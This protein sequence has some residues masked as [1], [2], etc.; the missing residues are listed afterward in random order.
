MEKVYAYI[1]HWT[2]LL[3]QKKRTLFVLGGLA[4]FLTLSAVSIFILLKFPNSGDEYLYL[5]WKMLGK[6]QSACW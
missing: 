6:G 4:V 2:D 1:T 3:L 5:Y